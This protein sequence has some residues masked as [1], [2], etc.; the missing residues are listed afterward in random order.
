LQTLTVTDNGRGIPVDEHPT[1]TSAR[2]AGG[3]LHHAARGGKFEQ[4]SYRTSGGLHGVG[5]SVVNALSSGA[6]GHVKRGGKLYRQ[7]FKRGA[8]QAPVAPVEP[9]VGARPGAPAPSRPFGPTTR[10]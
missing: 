9:W 5:A 3:H 1:E 6:R 10:S 4:G 2:S 8:P 7:R